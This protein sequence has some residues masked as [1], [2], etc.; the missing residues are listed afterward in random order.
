MAWAS[1]Y[2][3]QFFIHFFRFQRLEKAADEGD[4]EA[5]AAFN[6]SIRGFP[7]AMYAKMLGKRAIRLRAGHGTAR[8]QAR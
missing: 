1:Y 6:R 3:V 4:Q 8:K 2:T 7:G 5:A